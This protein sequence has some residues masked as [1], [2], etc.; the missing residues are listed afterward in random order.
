MVR[1]VRALRMLDGALPMTATRSLFGRRVLT[2]ALAPTPYVWGGKAPGGLDCSGLVTLALHEAGGPDLRQTANT[3]VLWNTLPPVEEEQL[4]VGDLALYWGEHSKGP[5]DVSHVMLWAGAGIVLGQHWG[6][7]GDVDPVVSR[8][9][10]KVTGAR[11]LLYR[12]DFAG[13][14]R[15]PLTA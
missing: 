8:L 9:A 13:F 7:P 10:G 11:P 1:R 15:L 14:R 12:T 6:G 5:E 3:D 2:H 4:E